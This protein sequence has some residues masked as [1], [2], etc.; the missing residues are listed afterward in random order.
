[1]PGAPLTLRAAARGDG[2]PL[3]RLVQA[4]GTL[5]VN[6]AYFYVLHAEHFGATCLVA[7]PADDPSAL[8]GAVIAHRPPSAPSAIFVWQVGVAPEARGQGLGKR[9]LRALLELPACRDA[10]HLTATVAPD[11]LASERLFRG[12][13]REL[14]VPCEVAPFFSA[15]LFPPGHAPEHL[16]RIGPLTRRTP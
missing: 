5:E 13:A 16:F 14:G 3:W 2:L 9:M 4:A 10:T 11:N 1:M 6:S 7:A 15:D 12:V 8:R